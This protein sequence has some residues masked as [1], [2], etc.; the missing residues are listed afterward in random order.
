MR[1]LPPLRKGGAGDSFVRVDRR[2]MTRQQKA[3]EEK[4]VWEAGG[5]MDRARMARWPDD[6]LRAAVA[7][8]RSGK[9]D[10]RVGW[11][12]WARPASGNPVLADYFRLDVLAEELV[13]RGWPPLGLNDP[14]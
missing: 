7:S 8:V 4:R 1:A 13:K 14:R 11:F 5:E 9:R 6:Q 2:R 10:G 3:D 12:L